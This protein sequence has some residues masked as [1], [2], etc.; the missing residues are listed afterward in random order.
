MD[1][2]FKI[3]KHVC[4]HKEPSYIF[5]SKTRKLALCIGINYKNR[6]IKYHLDG[7]NND[8]ISIVEFLKDN[9]YFIK[10]NQDIKILK[11]EAAT[12]KNILSEIKEIVK[13]ANSSSEAF[14]IFFY[15]SGHGIQKLDKNF[16]EFDFK[17]EALYCSDGTIILDDELYT[18]LI[19]PLKSHVTLFIL[20]DSC[21]SGSVFDHFMNPFKNVYLFSA[22]KESELAL[23]FSEGGIMT[24]TFKDRISGKRTLEENFYIIKNN[25]EEKVSKLTKRITQTPVFKQASYD[26]EDVYLFR[27]SSSGQLSS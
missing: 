13:K 22:C 6:D 10:E 9:C 18:A 3:M 24:T 1:T 8:L 21:H 15:Y 23:E 12:A 16:D 7:T 14:S 17:D 27:A 25:V 4:P 26:L 2:I 20:I 11:N 5:D 19:T